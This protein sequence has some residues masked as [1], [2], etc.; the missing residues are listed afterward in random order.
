MIPEL[1]ELPFI[2]ITVKSYGLMM[3][4]GFLFAVLLMRKMAKKLGENPENITNVALFALIAGV[5]GARILYVIHYFDQFRGNILSVFAVWNG[6]LEFVGGVILAVIFVLV[7]LFLKKWSIRRYLDLLVVGL[8]LGLAFGRIGCFLNGCC[9]GK[10]TDLALGVQFPYGSPSYYSQVFPDE[11][12][13]RGKAQLDLPTEY[14]GYSSRDGEKWIEATENT[15]YYSR[16]KPLRLLSDEQ[17]HEV[18]KGK[19][20]G[21]HVH[22]SQLYSSVN[23]LFVCS[24]L[25]LFWRKFGISRPG[26]TFG[27]MFV[28]YGTLRFFLE[29]I[30][31]DNPFE[32][33]W[34]IIYRGGTISQ[35]IGIYMVIIGVFM[36]PIYW[37]IASRKEPAKRQ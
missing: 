34:W 13:N 18:T 24:V 14:F 4:I 28:M 32:H 17:K 35:N 19:Y 5:V 20:C 16:L 23:A 15:K 33:A 12:R 25:Y 21:L 3:V 37:R 27:L 8:M 22:P 6:G 36:F 9:Y 10:P 30:R 7:F 11:V 29:T 26:C 2:H 1:F 31:D